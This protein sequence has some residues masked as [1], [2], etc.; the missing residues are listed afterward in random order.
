MT[1]SGFL[2]NFFWF[3]EKSYS[4]R[5]ED[6]ILKKLL[7]EFGINKPTYFDVGA[8]HP[9]RLSNTY[10]F[11]KTGARGVLVEPDK[12]NHS[13][14]LR[15]RSGDVAVWAVVGATP[16]EAVFHEFSNHTRSTIYKE[17]LLD[18]ERIKGGRIIDSYK[19]AVISVNKLFLDYGV[20]DLLCVDAEGMDEEIIK[21]IDFEKFRPKV[22]C[23][24]I[25][26]L[27]KLKANTLETIDEGTISFLQSKNY[28]FAAHTMAN[29]IFVD[30]KAWDKKIGLK[31][32]D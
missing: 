30:K 12:H 10:L 18:L 22:I 31:I 29:G 23:V 15:Q 9:K 7:Q 20:P 6:I 27:D 24:E 19:V 1:L 5:G 21:S 26:D 14:L 3:P 11:Y 17:N 13:L 16:C 25:V 8:N 32:N 2:N 4:Q 28:Y